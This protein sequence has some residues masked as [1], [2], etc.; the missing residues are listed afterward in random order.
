MRKS[1]HLF[2][3]VL[4]IHALCLTKLLAKCVGNIFVYVFVIE[5]TL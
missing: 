3:N 5:N 2:L 1:E 4:Y